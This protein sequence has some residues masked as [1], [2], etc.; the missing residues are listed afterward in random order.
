MGIDYV[1]AFIKQSWASQDVYSVP[2]APVKVGEYKMT[3]G[4]YVSSFLQSSK[5]SCMNN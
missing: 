3:K 1:N 2:A 4:S 5:G